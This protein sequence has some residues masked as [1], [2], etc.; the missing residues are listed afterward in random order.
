M[1]TVMELM[2]L[3][4]PGWQQTPLAIEWIKE[5]LNELKFDTS[6]EI[7]EEKISIVSGTRYYT[8]PSDITDLK[9]VLFKVPVGSDIAGSYAPMPRITNDEDTNELG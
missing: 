9:R 7:S 4:M 1:S 3:T 6:V 8:L 2:E 5:A